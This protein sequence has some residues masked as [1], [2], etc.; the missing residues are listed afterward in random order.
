VDELVDDLLN[1][2]READRGRIQDAIPKILRAVIALVRSYGELAEAV[3]ELERKVAK[4]EE[5]DPW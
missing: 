4:I 1:A 5:Q 2:E 3:K